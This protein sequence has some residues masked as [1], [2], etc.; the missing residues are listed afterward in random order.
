MMSNQKTIFNLISAMLAFIVNFLISFVLSPYI[1]KHIGVEAYGFFSLANNFVMYFSVIAFSVNAI[2]ARFI[3]IYMHKQELRRANEY[4]SSMCFAN[5]LFAGILL[6]I[7]IIGIM[8]LE[9]FIQ[10]PTDIIIDVKLLFLTIF[11][12]FLFN[13]FSAILGI[14]Y[15]VKNQLYLSSMIQIEGNIIRL[16]I[17]LLLFY[18]FIPHITYLGISALISV[19][20]MRIYDLYYK[21]KLIPDLQFNRI[22]IKWTRFK[23]MI[24][25]GIWNMIMQLGA[26]LSGNLDLLIVNLC[27]NATDMGILALSKIVPITLYMIGST[28]SNVFMPNMLELY[29]KQKYDELVLEIKK[30]LKIAFFVFSIPLV[31]FLVLGEDFFA[32]WVPN[33][34]H[35]L[36]Y[37]LS[38]LATISIIVIGP[39]IA[40]M[41]NIF[42]V[43][44]KLKTNSLLVVFTGFLASLSCFL[45]L[46]YTSLGLITVVTVTASLSLI[47]NL[48]Y[49]VPYGAIYLNRKWYTF[50]PIIIKA[51]SVICF[52]S[53]L[54]YFVKSF[55]VIDTWFLFIIASIIVI[56]CNIIIQLL[57]F[58]SKDERYLF[59]S[60]VKDKWKKIQAKLIK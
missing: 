24:S 29:A 47:R 17:L 59:I 4:Y 40:I 7:S 43:I 56:L 53:A 6:I 55:Y 21:K 10:I 26:V 30:T 41:Y 37:L 34:D 3:V 39:V 18:L 22:Y 9:Y 42:T 45:I 1:V 2:A 33:Q 36:L 16:I 46:K 50:F 60:K 19:V 23:E 20:F 54:G 25:S 32:L 58:L 5:V 11:I 57:I 44:N 28:L 27:L 49:T 52:I 13:M 48:A 14:S 31:S 51:F 15:I 38:M 12:S 35:R 8:D